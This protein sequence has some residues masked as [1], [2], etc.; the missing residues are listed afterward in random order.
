M[1]TLTLPDQ[2]KVLLIS[3]QNVQIIDARKQATPAVT[4]QPSKSIIDNTF[5][6][7]EGVM[8]LNLR[9]MTLIG[10]ITI[11]ASLLIM[12][13]YTCLNGMVKCNILNGDFPMVS[14]VIR[15]PFVDRIWCI[16]TTVYCW[17]ILQSNARAVYA[18]LYPFVDVEKNDHAIWVGCV[19]IITLPFIGYFDEKKYT[20]AH[21]I[22]AGLFFLGTVLYAHM[23]SNLFNSAKSNFA[24][25]KTISTMSTIR[26][27]MWGIA[28][29]F[30]ISLIFGLAPPL[31]EWI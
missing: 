16:L 8:S 23:I 17:T 19:P 22:I 18:R 14:S 4:P 12:L 24:E 21:G 28:G 2:S 10:T 20:I 27:V 25:Q 1:Q 15:Q 26:W 31:W 5:V 30:G 6:E 29:M 9:S 3:K 13:T 7:D 11:T